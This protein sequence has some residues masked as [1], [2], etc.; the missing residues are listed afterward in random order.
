MKVPFELFTSLMKIYH[1]VKTRSPPDSICQYLSTFFPYFS[2]LPRQHLR[3][4]VTIPLGRNRLSTRLSANLDV[5]IIDQCYMFRYKGV[6]LGRRMTDD[7]GR[8]YD[9]VKGLWSALT[10]A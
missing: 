3:V 5:L 7:P 8:E 2:V 1:A 4:E 9:G 6:I 10:R